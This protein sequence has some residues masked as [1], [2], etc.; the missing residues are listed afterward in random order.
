[1]KIDKDISDDFSLDYIFSYGLCILSKNGK[2]G[3]VNKNGDWVVEPNKWGI[4][5]K[6]YGFWSIP[7]DDGMWGLVSSD[8]S[9]ILPAKYKHINVYMF[10]IATLDENNVMREYDFKGNILRDDI[11]AGVNDLTYQR[12]EMY[13]D[14]NDETWKLVQG[15]SECKAYYVMGGGY[16]FYYGLMS[17]DG[18][19]ITK[20]IYDRITAISRDRYLCSPHGVILNSRGEVV[21]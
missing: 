21:K 14:K 6:G 20:P 19:R 16:D 9:E 11:I 5:Y 15:V 8:M 17:S 13:Y 3:L 12:S 10:H 1:M 7:A 18:R 2:Y 4:E